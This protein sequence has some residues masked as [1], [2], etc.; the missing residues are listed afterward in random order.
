MESSGG[1]IAPVHYRLHPRLGAGDQE[2][3]EGKNVPPLRERLAT[4]VGERKTVGTIA[5]AES[6]Q[7]AG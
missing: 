5:Y 6:P 4:D 1:R 3:A 2:M 7:A